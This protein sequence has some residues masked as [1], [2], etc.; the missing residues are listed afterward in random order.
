MAAGVP[1]RC[2]PV[3]NHLT[4]VQVSHS[5]W[6]PLN[7][8]HPVLQYI[9]ECGPP[10]TLQASALGFPQRY[11]RPVVPGKLAQKLEEG[12]PQGSEAYLGKQPEGEEQSRTHWSSSGRAKDWAASGTGSGAS[13]PTL[14]ALG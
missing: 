5:P 1:Q 7:T 13:T 10:W 14:R 11:S 9:R 12:M 4:A 2:S 3:L 6:K 8:G